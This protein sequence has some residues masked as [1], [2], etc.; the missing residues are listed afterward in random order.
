MEIFRRK[1]EAVASEL[2]EAALEVETSA[3]FRLAG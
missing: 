3:S 1:F 2:E